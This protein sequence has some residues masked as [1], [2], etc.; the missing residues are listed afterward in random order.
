MIDINLDTLVLP[1]TLKAPI[2]L[3]DF[4]DTFF[5]PDSGGLAREAGP[6]GAQATVPHLQGMNLYVTLHDECIAICAFSMVS[7]KSHTSVWFPGAVLTWWRSG[8]D[9]PPV[10][11]GWAHVGTTSYLRAAYGSDVVVVVSRRQFSDGTL[12]YSAYASHRDSHV[13]WGKVLHDLAGFVSEQDRPGVLAAL[14]SEAELKEMAWQN[15]V[16]VIK[17]LIDRNKE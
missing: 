15:S 6:Y 1:D 14:L 16:H 8:A 2:P 12:S 10:V 5:F 4:L 11:I 7:A 17:A 13:W 9:N 3:R